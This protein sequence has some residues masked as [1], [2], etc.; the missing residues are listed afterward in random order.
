MANDS[1]HRAT[2]FLVGGCFFMELLDGTIVSTAAPQMGA[3]LH[4]APAAIGLVITVYLLTLAV[5]IPLSGW[6]AARHG[7]RRVFLTAITLFTL[8]SLACAA[9]RDLGQLLAARILQ[10]AGGA[11]MVP[12]GRLVVLSRTAKPDLPKAMATIV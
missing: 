1:R 10:G 7:P 3:A 11:M 8:G 4:V 12:V 6:L 2:A 5:L 9:T